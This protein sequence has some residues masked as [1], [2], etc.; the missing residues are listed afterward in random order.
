MTKQLGW[1][2]FIDPPVDFSKAVVIISQ[3]GTLASNNVVR[4]DE[5]YY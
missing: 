2:D 4:K 1:W 5:E 3:E